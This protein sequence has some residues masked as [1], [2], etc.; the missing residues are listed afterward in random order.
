MNNYEPTH[1]HTLARCP[2]DTWVRNWQRNETLIDL[3]KIPKD[4]HD[5]ILREFKNMKTADR[6]KLFDY[7]VKKKQ[8]KK[9]DKSMNIK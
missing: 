5:D 8:F 1:L 7:F 6:G 4:I 2:K 9:F 3:N